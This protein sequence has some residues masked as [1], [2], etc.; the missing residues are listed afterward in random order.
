MDPLKFRSFGVKRT[1][2]EKPELDQSKR[3]YPQGSKGQVDEWH[4]VVKLQS[5]RIILKFF[6]VILQHFLLK[7]HFQ[8]S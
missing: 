8:K 1:K 2:D 3:N 7:I 6:F 5:E 4:A